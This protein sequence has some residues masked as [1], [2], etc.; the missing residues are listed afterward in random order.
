[1]KWIHMEGHLDKYP[2]TSLGCEEMF[3]SKQIAAKHLKRVHLGQKDQCP[4]CSE[5]LK[6]LSSHLVQ[7]HQMGK[8]H[9]CDECGKVFYKGHDLKVHI[10]KVHEGKKHT[11][12]EC[13]KTV[14]KIKDHMKSIHGVLYTDIRSVQT[15]N[16]ANATTGTQ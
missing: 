12:P 1:M 3:K 16:S 6:N 10:E 15:V 7:V 2:C 11:C 9:M 4:I 5:W 14:A 8:K 13:G